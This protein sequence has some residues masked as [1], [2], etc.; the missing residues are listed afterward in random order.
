VLQ[1]RLQAAT[2]QKAYLTLVMQTAHTILE[3]PETWQ[4]RLI[5]DRCARELRQALKREDY[6]TVAAYKTTIKGIDSSIRL[7]ATARTL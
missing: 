5:R 3:N 4:L 6:E 1:K 7:L 2:E